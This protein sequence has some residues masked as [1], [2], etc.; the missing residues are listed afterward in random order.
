MIEFSAVNKSFGQHPAVKDLT[1]RL[2][3]GAFSVLI[4]TSGSGNRPRSK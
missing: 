2:E 4:G 1:L 3:E